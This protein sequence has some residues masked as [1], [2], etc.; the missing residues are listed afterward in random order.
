M[1][2]HSTEKNHSFLGLPRMVAAV[3]IAVAVL[4]AIA[5]GCTFTEIKAHPAPIT[6]EETLEA[7]E[8]SVEWWDDAQGV[9][10]VAFT[11]P[12]QYEL[13]ENW[14]LHISGRAAYADGMSMSRHFFEDESWKAGGR[15]T[16]EINHLTELTMQAM[17]TEQ[18]GNLY[19][20]EINLLPQSKESNR[21]VKSVRPTEAELEKYGVVYDDT[22]RSM[23]ESYTI[24]SDSAITETSQELL[25]RALR[26]KLA[27]P[28]DT[29]Q[30]R[31]Y[32]LNHEVTLPELTVEDSGTMERAAFTFLDFD[33][34]GTD[35]VVYRRGN[36]RGFYV[37]RLWEGKVYGYEINYRGMMGLKQDGTFCASGGAGD[38]GYCH[39]R[40][41]D[42]KLLIEPFM[43]HVENAQGETCTIEGENVSHEVYLRAMETQD[44]KLDA[45]WQED[46]SENLIEARG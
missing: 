27:F 42:L 26:G 43:W 19:E 29:S 5:Y 40:F 14:D 33:G 4:V 25:L 35:E 31:S 16:I 39:L 34:D 46:T 21:A 20:R 23:V 38:N 30:T 45:I 2:N 1:I 24:E 12:A 41:N 32:S 44:A 22:L 15:Y 11:L 6:E 7:L 37:L 18:N 36:Y 10:Y 13:V 9:R 17:L 8:A 3:M 28:L